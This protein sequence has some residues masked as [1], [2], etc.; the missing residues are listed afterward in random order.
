MSCGH[1]TQRHGHL[2][3]RVG[4]YFYFQDQVPIRDLGDILE[5]V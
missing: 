2:M 3:V 1:S 4:E 5:T